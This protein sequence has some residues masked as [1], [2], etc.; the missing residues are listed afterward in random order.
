MLG[1]V[2]RAEAQFVLSIVTARQAGRA[3]QIK[4]KGAHLM[5]SVIIISAS[6]LVLVAIIA[7]VVKITSA[8]RGKARRAGYSSLGEY[9]RAAPRSDE[10]K[11]DAVDLSLGGLVICLLGLAFP[12]FLL[13]GIIP[14]FYGTRKLVYSMMGFGLFDDADPPSQ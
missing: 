6:L 11:R 5:W 4:G 9:L 3:Y 8:F 14:F 1:C 10:E 13:I 7:A 2:N 12:P